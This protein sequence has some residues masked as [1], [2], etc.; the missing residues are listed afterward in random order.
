MLNVKR[1]FQQ[2]PKL[3]LWLP[4][5]LVVQLVTCITQV[6]FYH[7]D[8]HFQIIEFS[9]YQL[10]KPNSASHVWEMTDFIRPTLQV[11]LFSGY[12]IVCGFFKITDPYLQLT[13]LRIILGIGMFSLFNLLT[14]Y[15]LKNEKKNVLHFSLLILTLSWILPYIRTLYSSEILSAFFFFG[16]LLLYE[17]NRNKNRDF[18]IALITG[19]LFSLSFYCRFQM[20]FA[21]AGFGVWMIFFEKQYL[22]LIPVIVGFIIGASANTLLDYHFYHQFIITPYSYF[23]V[24]INQGKA[25][26]FGTSSFLVYVGVL[27]A[28]VTVPPLSLFLL[29][30]SIKP[31]LKKYS[32]P[33][34]IAVVFLLLATVSSG[35]KKNVLFFL[36]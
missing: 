18:I 29:Y 1:F 31:S 16:G 5:M 30:Y 10:N 24:N 34:F 36:C 17:I 19:F 2:Y 20:G 11:Y 26:S 9:S 33:V 13:I 15:Y 12:T 21:I 35:T 14:I 7:P 32:Q 25:S 4:V 22:K 3:R 23:H 27:A 28:T 8:Q 6:G